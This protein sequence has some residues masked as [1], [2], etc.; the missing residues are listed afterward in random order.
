MELVMK[1]GEWI[2]DSSTLGNGC[3]ELGLGFAN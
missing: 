1:L 3:A 2:N